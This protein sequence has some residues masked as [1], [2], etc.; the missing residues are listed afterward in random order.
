[1]VAH[2]GPRHLNV[3]CSDQLDEGFR[4]A[5]DGENRVDDVIVADSG[6]GMKCAEN[7]RSDAN[8]VPPNRWRHHAR[9]TILACGVPE[10]R[11]GR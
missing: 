11:T 8:T 2:C 1:V 3:L 9:R 10:R 7:A 4:D 6:A 5:V